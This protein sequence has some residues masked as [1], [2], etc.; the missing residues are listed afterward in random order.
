MTQNKITLT[1]LIFISWFLASAA[2][3]QAPPI[4]KSIPEL[5]SLLES[6][7]KRQHVAG[8][9]LTIVSKDSVL[10]A[11]G[12]GYADVE[13]K[14]PV[15]ERHLFRQGSI[16]KLFTAVAVLK[17]VEEGKLRMDSRLKDIAP[18]IPFQNDWEGKHPVTIAQLLEHSTGFHDKT[19]LEEFNY[20]DKSSGSLQ[21]LG[22]FRK[23]LVTQWRPG[24]RHSYSNVNYAILTYIIEKVSGEPFQS[25]MRAQVFSPLGMPQANVQL[26]NDTTDTYSK[27]YVWQGNQFRNVPHRPQYV[28]GYGSLNA[29]ALDFAHALQVYLRDWKTPDGP[30]LSEQ[31]L[32]RSETPNTYLSAHAGM[33]NTY[34]CG[35][36]S[37]EIG[38]RVFRGHSG[39]IAGYLSN[40]L[41]SREMGHGF[42][43]SINTY[44]EGFY[45]YATDLI[46]KFITQHHP[47]PD[48]P[49][50]FP[51]DET[52]VKPYLGYYRLSSSSDFYTGYFKSLQRTFKLEQEQNGL[53]VNFL[54]GSS[55]AWKSADSSRLLFTNEWANDPRILFLRDE[56][57]KPV[58]VEDTLYFKKISALEAWVPLALLLLSL[59]LQ[60]SALVYSLVS[61][62]LILLKRQKNLKLFMLKMSPALA[63]LALLLSIWTLSQF[64]AY[65]MA[66]IPISNLIVLWSIGKYGFVLFTLATVLLLM[67][68]WKS[69]QSAWLKS[70]FLM[71][72]LSCCFILGLLL[73]SHW[74][75]V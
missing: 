22:A 32:Y 48:K 43:F 16:T 49:E 5:T 67:L 40:F 15:T 28:A 52:A 6:E 59:F 10:Y 56:E 69:V 24:E 1:L 68:C 57:N 13:R 70:Y 12:L 47:K 71:L 38:G 3:A 20:T 19:P 53:R 72:S 42:A 60:L 27:G 23:Y 33:Q 51:L 17:L 8:M 18:E 62:I 74:H 21:A 45:R 4:P 61:A 7:M 14:T 55:M 50:V 37:R 65:T 39:S 25:Y 46:A 44:N 2:L 26:T 58:I 11:D 54:L 29:S 9:M 41:Y 64:T 35:N 36:E 34:A 66:G 63:M 73:I 31:M 75:E 30:F